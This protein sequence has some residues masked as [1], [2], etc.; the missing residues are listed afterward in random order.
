V[1][2]SCAGVRPFAK[3]SVVKTSEAI[4]DPFRKASVDTE[5]VH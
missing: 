3:I 1:N 5:S 4:Q 2:V